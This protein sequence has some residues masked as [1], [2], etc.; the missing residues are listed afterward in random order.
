MGRPFITNKDEI[1]DFLKGHVSTL[2]NLVLRTGINQF[3][4]AAEGGFYARQLIR[5]SKGKKMKLNM[6]PFWCSNFLILYEF[7]MALGKRLFGNRKSVKIS[8]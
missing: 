2:D 8:S 4:E 5:F 1:A 7:K 3:E 6:S